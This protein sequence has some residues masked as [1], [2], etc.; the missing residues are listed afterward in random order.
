MTI[1][2]LPRSTISFPISCRSEH[3]QRLCTEEMSPS[4]FYY[5]FVWTVIQSC[6]VPAPIETTRLN[7][8]G[9]SLLSLCRIKREDKVE[10]GADPAWHIPTVWTTHAQALITGGQHDTAC[11]L[12]SVLLVP[13]VYDYCHSIFH[14][15]KSITIFLYH[16][17][18]SILAPTT[19]AQPHNAALQL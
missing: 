2:S 15:S 16:K 6:C 8:L 13:L 12:A 11:L 1:G 14:C 17:R 18:D 10:M 19:R 7:V 5:I 4:G 3:L 9:L